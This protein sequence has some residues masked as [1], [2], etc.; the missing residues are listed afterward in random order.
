MK[1]AFAASEAAPFIKTGGLADVA[2]SLPAALAA[3]GH[4]VTVFVPLYGAIKNGG[5]FKDFSFAGE[6]KTP[7]G[8]RNQYTGLFI[9]QDGK[10]KP[11]FCFIDNEYYFCRTN[12]TGIYGEP[13]DGERFAFFSRAVIESFSRLGFLPDVVHCND[14][15][16]ALL[17]VFLREFYP[18]Y[19]GIKTLFTIHNIE[20]QGVM[21]MEFAGDVAGL[22]EGATAD[23]EWGGCLNLMKGAIVRS[24]CLTTVSR[25]YAEEILY[26]YYSHGLHRILSENRAK[27][28]G[29]VNGIDTETYDPATDPFIRENYSAA[30][31]SG[32][33]ADKRFLQE[34]LGL[35]TDDDLP[36]IGMVTRLAGHKGID[37][38]ERVI[39][40]IAGLG[41]Q[42]AVLG[43]GEQRYEEMLRQAEKRHPDMISASITFSPELASQ[44][45]AG[46]DVFLMPSESEP[47]GLSQMVAMR[48]GA[49][50]VVRETGG[51][52]DTVPAYRMLEKTGRGFTFWEYNAHEMLGAVKRCTAFYRYERDNFRNLQKNNMLCDF[53]WGASEKEYEEI[54]EGL[55]GKRGELR[56]GKNPASSPKNPKNR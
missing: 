9:C 11:R 22:G 30:D 37:L 52:K 40:E 47:C 43:T 17:P 45:Y 4:E 12:G 15:H 10:N 19:D 20:Y 50:P 35:R 8:W 28:R 31:M 7:L 53:S 27:L 55:A 25:T 32:K 14:W 48:Y 13:D 44:I 42:L 2:A 23:L 16:T 6:F 26:E 56:S 39:D 24:D 21:P 54:Y 29:V 33:A 51:L 46:C 18:Q 3:A 5:Y 36:L 34:K 1:I 38:L 41:I 49:V